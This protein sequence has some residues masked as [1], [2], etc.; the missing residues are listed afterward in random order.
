LKYV[1]AKLNMTIGCAMQLSIF[2]LYCVS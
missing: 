2:Q 1:A